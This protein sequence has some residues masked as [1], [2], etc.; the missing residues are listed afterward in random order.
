MYLPL[1]LL[2]LLRMKCHSNIIV[3]RLQGCRCT[4]P[5]LT[6]SHHKLGSVGSMP[7]NSVSKA[8]PWATQQWKPHNPMVISFESIWMCDRQTDMVMPQVA[9]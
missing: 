3:D 7:R 8:S 2:L 1:L 9:L 5:S 6:W 4:N